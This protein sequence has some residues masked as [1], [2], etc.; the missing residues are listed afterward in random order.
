MKIG[1]LVNRYPAVSHSFIRR[2]I[3]GIEAAGGEVRRYSIRQ[4]GGDLPDQRDRAERDVT[5]V[6]LDQGVW[7]LF[8]ATL[9]MGISRPRAFFSAFGIALRSGG[10][11]FSRILRNIAYF[12]EACWLATDLGDIRHIHAH[13]G[14]NPAAVARLV[15]R[16]KGTT[17]SFTV[18]GPDEFDAPISLGLRG[19]CADASLVVAISDYGRSQLMRWS[20]MQDWVKIKVARCGVD[21]LFLENT[22][23]PDYA[24]TQL[25]CVARLSAQ[26]GIPLLLEATAHLIAGAPGLRLILVGDGELRK[27]IE[28]AIERLKITKHVVITGYVDA[29][30]VKQIMLQSRAMVLPSFAE[31][32]PVVI[33]EAL[34]LGLPVITTRIAGI[35]ELV[36]SACGWLIPP[37]SIDALADAMNEAITASASLLRNMG[38]VGRDR[39][40]AQHDAAVNAAG[41]YQQ[42]EATQS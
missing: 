37:G 7:A 5:T 9:R 42:I 16:L 22:S 26:K 20:R 14:T 23:A 30:T 4:P 24:N 17:F 19:K 13:F 38:Q 28:L 21:Q 31:G 41:L 1:Y 2:E 11:D 33:M 32:L 34:A 29:A 8:L 6:I 36:D 35:P 12:V 3:A 10:S 25:C 18:H 27:E 40:A 39:V 15:H